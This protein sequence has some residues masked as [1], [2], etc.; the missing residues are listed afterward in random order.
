MKKTN[1]AIVGYG[2]LGRA[3]EEILLKKSEYNLV[4]IFSRRAVE[5]VYK[6]KVVNLKNINDYKGKIDILFL[7]VG[8]YS[9]IENCATMLVTNFNI[10]DCF[11]THKKLKSYISN[12]NDVALQSKTVAL[13][14][15]GWDP[16]LMSLM[17]M[18]FW[19]VDK[20]SPC[21]SFWG[22]GV[23]QGHS[24]A[25]RRVKGVKNALQYTLPNNE[26]LKKCKTLFNY[27]PLEHEKH[28]RVCYVAK[29]PF[30]DKNKIKQEILSM[31]NYFLGYDTEI[32]FV[33]EKDIARRQKKLYHKGYVFKNFIDGSHKTKL[34][35]CLSTTSNPHLTA[36]LMIMGVQAVTTLAK[37]KNFGAYSIADIPIKYY[38]VNKSY[39][40][41]L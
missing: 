11:D 18:L 23:S 15:F 40:D 25:L 17:R 14:A 7:A 5:S 34:Q 19:A 10:V 27:V 39:F 13:S 22:K 9:D 4:A 38:F 16:G 20:N 36:T 32:N 24:D 28:K 30:A 12:L 8:S 26:I 35:F 3:L 2:N 1:V 21:E 6:T 41:F 29:E 37:A 31:P 33:D